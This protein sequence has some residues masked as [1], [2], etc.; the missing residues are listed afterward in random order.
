MVT[1]GVEAAFTVGYT[2]G[3]GDAG[4]MV[5]VGSLASIPISFVVAVRAHVTDGQSGIGGKLLLNPQGPGDQRGR[6]HVGLNAAGHQLRARGHGGRGVD[7]KARDRQRSNAVSWIEGR[8]LVGAV[9]Q[10]VL[11]VVVHPESGANHRLPAERTPSQPDSRLRE[12]FG[13]VGGED[14]IANLR[15]C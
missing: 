9:A 2:A 11:Q 15:L 13:V 4:Q 14:G 12:E 10:R 6:F 5:G 3:Q 1:G 8:V 7:G